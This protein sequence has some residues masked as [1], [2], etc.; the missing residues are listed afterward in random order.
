MTQ[1]SANLSEIFGRAVQAQQAGR[2]A[3]AEALYH[4]ILALAPGQPDA[5][6]MLG[7][8]AYQ[9]GDYDAAVD[10]IGRAIRAQ[11]GVPH[12]HSNLGNALKALGRLSDA[13]A[14]YRAALRLDPRFADVHNNLGGV[15]RRL[16]RLEDAKQCYEAALRLAPDFPEA[17]SNLGNVLKD[18][19]QPEAAEASYH[20][21]LRLRPGYFEAWNNLGI[22]YAGQRRF[23]RAADALQRVLAARPDDAAAHDALGQVQME[24]GLYPAAFASFRT[25]AR[26]DPSNPQFWADWAGCLGAA[27]FSFTTVDDALYDDLQRLLEQPETLGKTVMRSILEALG[28]HPEV[29]HVAAQ[30]RA[31][32]SEGPGAYED[33]AERL[34]RVPL[35]LRAITLACVNAPDFEAML[36]SLRRGFLTSVAAGERADRGLPFSMALAQQCFTNEYAFAETAA[37]Q[38]QVEQLAQTVGTCV[39]A[40]QEMPAGWLAALAAYRPLVG[41]AWAPSLLARA[42]VPE[43]SDLVRRQ[44]AEPL[45]ERG[46]RAS[47]PRLTAIRDAVSQAVRGQYEDN[48]YP[49]WIKPALH[50]RP[51]TLADILRQLFPHLAFD[52]AGL[53]TQPDVLI[54]GCGT[55]RQALDAATMYAG[56]R[57]LAVDLS[58]ASL[59]YAVRKTRELGL[60]NVEYAQ[61]DLLEL[62]VLTQ[63]FDVIECS[64]VLH[65]LKDPLAGW[66]VLADRLRP[67]GLMRIGLYSELARRGIVQARAMIAAKGYTDSPQDIRRC[68]QDLL[69]LAA[70]PVSA[71]SAPAMAALVQSDMYSLSE[72]RD[73]LFHV[74]E[75]RFTIPGIEAALRELGLEFLGFETRTVVQRFRA[76]NPDPTALTSLAAWHR[77]E[78]ENPDSFIGMYQFWCRKA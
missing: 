41:F 13:E 65:H 51:D 25:A 64:G 75:H 2:L 43:L 77:F 50:H 59:S 30:W 5:L 62:G 4:Q 33:A 7:V 61:A 8:V 56:A 63:S 29:R 69:A 58:L 12:Y 74:Q 70:D 53:P 1:A 47:I 32:G 68:R 3:E 6:H 42:P 72:C 52:A 22:L 49:R 20:A 14:S 57:V 23:D 40:G 60:T 34:S 28:H 67:G 38:T 66:R 27:S 71:A 18:L 78:T 37:E 54:A 48:P 45:A 15:L 11:P 19:R 46:L 24:M 21:A 16:G 26:L 76:A 55:G 36:T 44:V 9:R 73:L 10:Q 35:L 17:H 31:G 39:A